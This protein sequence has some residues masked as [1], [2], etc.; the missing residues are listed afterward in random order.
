MPTTSTRRVLAAAAVA[1][2][3][4]AGV[5][6]GDD[7]ADDAS[8]ATTTTASA[9]G[10]DGVT[11]LGSAPDP[12]ATRFDPET[13]DPLVT[14]CDGYFGYMAEGDPAFLEDINL[15]ADVIGGLDAETVDAVSYLLDDPDGSADPEQHEAAISLGDQGFLALCG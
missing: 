12:G 14:L 11:D 2:L 4:L 9:A 1:V 13:D 3:A 7:D 10:D 6:C 5:A 15:A 8:S